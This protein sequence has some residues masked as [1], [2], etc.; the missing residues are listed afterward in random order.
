MAKIE[1]TFEAKCDF[2]ARDQPYVS[3]SGELYVHLKPEMFK[4]L[5]EMAK[6]AD[7]FAEVQGG[8]HM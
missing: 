3:C 8:I 2:K 4:N 7:L 6:Q 5:D 1:N